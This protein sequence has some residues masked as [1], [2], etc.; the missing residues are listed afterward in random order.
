[1]ADAPDDKPRGMLK[2]M[3]RFEHVIIAALLVMMMLAI[4]VATIDLGWTLVQRLVEPPVLLL[5]VE[6][7]S[8]IF[9]LVFMIL[10]GLELLETVKTYLA[11]DQ[12]HVEVVFLV[13]MIAVARKV[14]LLDAKKLEPTVLYGVAAIIAA[15]AV[16]FFFVKL[17]YR[18]SG[19]RT[20]QKGDEPR[21]DA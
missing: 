1:M 21:D 13:A 2:V 14:I 18:K 10:I 5:Q 15:L 17:A 7:I 16:G 20:S 3:Q 4:L 11:K 19:G 6:E 9:G 8:E 12:L